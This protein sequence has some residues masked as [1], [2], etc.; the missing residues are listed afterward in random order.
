[1]ENI[2]SVM[3]QKRGDTDASWDYSKD[4]MLGAAEAENMNL[5]SWRTV[6]GTDAKK[7]GKKVA[8]KCN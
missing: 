8:E 7:M 3:I 1:M 2:V 4:K 6:P 5:K